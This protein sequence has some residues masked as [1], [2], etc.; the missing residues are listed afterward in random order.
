MSGY[1]NVTVTADLYNATSS[2]DQGIAYLT[3]AVG[4]SATSG[5][6]VAS[7]PFTLGPNS[8]FANT[9]LFTGLNLSPGTY[10]LSLNTTNGT[11]AGWGEVSSPNVVVDAGVTGVGGAK[12]LGTAVNPVYQ[13]SFTISDTLGFSVVA[14][15]NVPAVPESSSLML[16]LPAGLLL[17]GLA[18]AARR[19]A[20]QA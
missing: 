14:E 12:A 9:T 8:G 10:Y 19:R 6:V 18:L 7:A 2:T 3:T 1:N 16:I 5:D 4:S 11:V 17:A 13:S 20:P 15:P